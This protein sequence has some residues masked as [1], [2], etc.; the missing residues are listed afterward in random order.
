MERVDRLLRSGED[1]RLLVRDAL[2]FGAPPEGAEVVSDLDLARGIMD[3]V[4][5]DRMTDLVEEGHAAPAK[6]LGDR[7]LDS[8][9]GSKGGAPTSRETRVSYRND[10]AFLVALARCLHRAGQTGGALAY[11][12]PLA[13]QDAR[14]LGVEHYLG[15]LDAAGTIGVVGKASQL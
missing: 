9:P 2:V 6:R 1:R 7:S 13:K 8:N 4:L 12:H 14:L 11:I 10:R 3:R 5:R 15:R